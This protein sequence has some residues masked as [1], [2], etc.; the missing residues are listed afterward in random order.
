MSRLNVLL[1]GIVRG[2]FPYMIRSVRSLG[3]GGSVRCL[4][5]KSF[6]IFRTAFYSACFLPCLGNGP[7]IVAIRSLVPR[8][9][10]GC[11]TGSSVRVVAQ[12][13]LMS[14]TSTVITISRRAGESLVRLCSIPRRGVAII[15]R[16][17]PPG[18]VIADISLIGNPC[19]LCVNVEHSC[20]GFS[21]LIVSF[22]QFIRSR[23]RIGLVYANCPFDLRRR[24]LFIGCGIIRGVFRLG[25]GSVRIGGLCTGTV[26]FVCPSL[27]RKFKVP[28]LRTFT[29]KY[30]ILLGGGD[31]FPRVTDCTNVF[32]DSSTRD[33]GVARGLRRVCGLSGRGQGRLVGGKCGELSRFS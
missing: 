10:P 32:F 9:F 1:C 7:F 6:S 27:C 33:S 8:L 26:K 2:L 18:R 23:P 19:F 13:A 20:G 29:C 5:E 11:F 16:T 21:R 30:P 14:G 24:R 25:T 15:C 17:K 3:V 22:D 28:V 12:G 4:R 31:Y